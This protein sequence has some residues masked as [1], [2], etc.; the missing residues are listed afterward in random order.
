MQA[1]IKVQGQNEA[2]IELGHLQHSV[3]AACDGV[4]GSINN[5]QIARIAR[6]AG[7]PM[8][9][10]AGVD[11]HCKVDDPVE[12][13]QTLYTIYAEFNADYNFARQAAERDNGFTISK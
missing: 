12:K 1:I 2:S 11:L 13:G 7:A 3:L 4:V 9:K 5:L 6:L 10:G 8:D